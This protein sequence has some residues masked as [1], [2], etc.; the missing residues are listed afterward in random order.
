MLRCRSPPARHPRSTS[1]RRRRARP[2]RAW[3]WRVFVG[4]AGDRAAA[5]AGRGR[6]RRAV[7]GGLRRRRAAG[8]GRAARR[9]RARP[10]WA[11]RCAPS[12]PTAAGAAGSCAWR[13]ARTSRRCAAPIRTAD[14][15][16]TANRFAVPGVL[17]L[18]A[19]GAIA[20][21][22]AATRCEGAWSDGLRLSTSLASRA[23][24]LSDWAPLS[25]ARSLLVSHPGCA[26]CRRPAATRSQRRGLC[27]YAVVESV[28]V[29]VD[30]AGPYHAELRTLAAFERLHGTGSPADTLG[31]GRRGRLRHRGAG[32]PAG[33]RHPAQRPAQ[34]S[35]RS[36]CASTMPVPAHAR[37]RP[38]GALRRCGRRRLAAHRPPR[39]HAGLRRQP[40][41]AGHVAR[42]TRQASG[43]AWRE[44][45]S[46]LAV[47]LNGL[48]QRPAARPRAARRRRSRCSSASPASA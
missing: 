9:A 22:I 20:A 45:G 15:V 19:S 4:F 48:T 10:T 7:R 13:A 18:P 37:V 2:C 30:A 24:A 23:L 33:Q 25:H 32:H 38:L 31:H 28:S 44:L 46:A 39:T 40:A 16:A 6:E 21:A 26:A 3:T 14:G 12:S 11:A 27:A 5:P 47:R 42:S 41:G 17:A 43:P 35:R 1:R 34:P 36:V 8:L 29:V